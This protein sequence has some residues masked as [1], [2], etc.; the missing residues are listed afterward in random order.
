MD[1]TKILAYPCDPTVATGTNAIVTCTVNAPAF[2][3][4]TLFITGYEISAN[5]T[6]AQAVEATLAG[7]AVTVP[8]EIPAAAFAPLMRDFSTHPLRVVGGA[9]AVLSVP[10]LGSG[11]KCAVT[12]YTFVASAPDK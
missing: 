3:A 7:P 8:L 9:N 6:P 2:P 4:S 1:T 5:G 11:I 10:A 12:L